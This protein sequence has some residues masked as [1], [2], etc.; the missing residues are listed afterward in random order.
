MQAYF[1]SM[2]DIK[3]NHGRCVVA[4]NGMSLEIIFDDKDYRKNITLK[5]SAVYS[6]GVEATTP[7]WEILDTKT[8]LEHRWFYG[9]LCPVAE[10]RMWKLVNGLYGF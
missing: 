7:R 2:D 6:L 9:D 8:S 1:Q 4:E 5:V 3:R 10:D